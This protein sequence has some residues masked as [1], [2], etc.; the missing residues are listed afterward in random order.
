VQ[1]H[2]RTHSVYLTKRGSGEFQSP[3]RRARF[4]QHGPGEYC[5]LIDL[6][7]LNYFLVTIGTWSA[8]VDRNQLVTNG[9][10]GGSFPRKDVG[11]GILARLNFGK[12]KDLTPGEALREDG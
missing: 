7:A 8:V 2:Y 6:F 11:I 1:P 5:A 12:E 4:S 9:G 3:R 10:S